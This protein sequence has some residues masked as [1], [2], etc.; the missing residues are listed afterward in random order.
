MILTFEVILIEMKYLWMHNITIHINSYQ[1][2][3]I[4][5]CVR[6]KKKVTK[7]LRQKLDIE[8]L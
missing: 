5:E 6:K 4:N 2:R 3:F 8:L 1:N 7:K